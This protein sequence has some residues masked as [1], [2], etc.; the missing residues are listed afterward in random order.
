MCMYTCKYDFVSLCNSRDSVSIPRVRNYQYLS[1][2]LLSCVIPGFQ[3]HSP[4]SMYAC[5][6]FE[7]LGGQAFACGTTHQKIPV[8]H[9][10]GDL[11]YD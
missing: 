3:V 4:H 9:V 6:N 11:Y 5:V 7:N 8:K 1:F 10:Y 2:G